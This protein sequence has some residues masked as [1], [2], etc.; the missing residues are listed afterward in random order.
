MLDRSSILA[1]HREYATDLVDQLMSKNMIGVID[2][3][4]CVSVSMSVSVS[5]NAARS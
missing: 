2:V 4:G 1:S 5:V 3:H